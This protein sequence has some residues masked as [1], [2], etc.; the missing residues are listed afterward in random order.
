MG[1]IIPEVI[2]SQATAWIAGIATVFDVPVDVLP[3]PLPVDLEGI[4]TTAFVP[5]AF[6]NGLIMEIPIAT[7]QPAFPVII[8][9]PQEASGGRLRVLERC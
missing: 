6:G 8:C 7:I 9:Q 5:D 2:N 4:G 3:S 1:R